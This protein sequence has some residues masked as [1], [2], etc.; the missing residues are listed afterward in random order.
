[1][2]SPEFDWDTLKDNVVGCK[3]SFCK[4]GSFDYDT[5]VLLLVYAS[6]LRTQ[7]VAKGT[8]GTSLFSFPATELAY[9]AGRL[10]TSDWYLLSSA[11]TRTVA[12]G[13]AASK[14]V[15][16]RR[17]LSATDAA[18]E[19]PLAAAESTVGGMAEELARMVFFAS[20]SVPAYDCAPS[21]RNRHTET[22]P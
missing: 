15:G 5:Y 13:L 16:G 8:G 14:T 2:Y 17:R 7:S 3:G 1:L 19:K 10:N 11:E 9:M 21:P 20:D 22:C 18:R 6:Q 12:N 4:D